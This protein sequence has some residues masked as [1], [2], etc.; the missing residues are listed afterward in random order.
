[1]R[2]DK[3]IEQKSPDKLRAIW[4]EFLEGDDEEGVCVDTDDIVKLLAQLGYTK[5]FDIPVKMRGH[6]WYS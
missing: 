3:E 2:N 6:Y 4:I 1:M 5:I